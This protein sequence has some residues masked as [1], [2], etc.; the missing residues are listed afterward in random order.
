MLII[1]IGIVRITESTGSAALG[2]IDTLNNFSLLIRLVLFV[3]PAIF[4]AVMAAI[5][6]TQQEKRLFW[7]AATVFQVILLALIRPSFDM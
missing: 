1:F 6:R 2:A 3:P 7:I 4:C 5:R